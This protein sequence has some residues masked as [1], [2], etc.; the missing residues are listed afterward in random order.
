MNNGY[1]MEDELQQRAYDTRIMLR[2]LGYV[3][4]WRAWLGLASLLLLLLSVLGNVTPLLVMHSV[5]RHINNPARLTGGES[6]DIAGLWRMV[7]AI[8]VLILAQALLRY[9]QVLIV[10]LVGQRAMFDMRMRLFTH[11]QDF[12]LRFLDRNPAGR[13][14]S[15]LTTDIEKVQ[16]TIVEGVVAMVSDFMTLF[17][18]LVIML[19]VNWVLALIALAPLPLVF[20]TS[21]I[22]RKYA[23]RSFLEVRRK[24]AHINAWMQ[25]NI[26]GMRL[27]RL[28]NRED[29]NFAEYEHRNAVHRDEWL[30]QIR[31]FALYFPA[32]EFLSSL[33]TALI[34]LYCG[35]FMLRQGGS[36]TGQGSIGTIFAFVFLAER[37]FGPIRALADRYN[38][39]LEAMASSER[40]FQLQDTVPDIQNGPNPKACPQVSGA[41]SL[42]RVWF[43]YDD[44]Q[45]GKEPRWVLKD[46]C[47]DIRPGERVAIVG[48]TGAGKSTLTH[49]LSRFYDIQR[50]AIRVDGVD[51]RD[52]DLVQLRR[53]IG[54]VL[55]EVFLFSGTI[56]ENIRL[57]DNGMGEEHVLACAAHVNAAPF[58]GRLP[59][60]YEYT[61]GERGGNLSV[62]QRQLIAFAR[63]LAH[64]PRIL[65]LDEATASIDTE[66]EH[67]IQDALEKLL[68]G[69]TSIVIAHRLSTIQ[70]ADRIVVMHHGEIREMGT[71]QELL[72]QNGLYRTL[73]ELQ[74]KAEEQH[75]N[76]AN[77]T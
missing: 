22:F 6:A 27:V 17:A 51:V 47:L 19:Y 41:V 26:S 21:V 29:A 76:T 1:H 53:N 40:V 30:R 43:S 4:P 56:D 9:A 42:D 25:E 20:A 11:F 55:Q 75:D 46:L 69:R 14:L 23:Q 74:Y 48:H 61:V 31:N 3:R 66:T 10:S 2:L 32:V 13:L 45:P 36:V 35:L 39:I 70:H 57:G 15:R 68:A 54:V 28:F 65:V 44:P 37:F 16:Q 63:T 33:S 52:Y 72:A 34:L 49:L 50:G 64:N 59:G 71:H 8:G 60:K 73:Y 38:L 77:K 7:A 67:L 62:G 24:I 12:S 18:V 58:I 5:D